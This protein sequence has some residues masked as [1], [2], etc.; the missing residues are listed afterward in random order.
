MSGAH[1]GQ[2]QGVIASSTCTGMGGQQVGF[3]PPTRE[4]STLRVCVLFTGCV[5]G[6]KLHLVLFV[7]ALSVCAGG[8]WPV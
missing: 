4:G 6:N 2:E 7:S 1:L 5:G 8:T 3:H